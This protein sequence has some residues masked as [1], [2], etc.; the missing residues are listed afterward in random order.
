MSNFYNMTIAEDGLNVSYSS[1]TIL[2]GQVVVFDVIGHFVVV[3]ANYTF[4]K[5]PKKVKA[6]L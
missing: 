1:K 5:A 2:A 4:V 3:E 6:N